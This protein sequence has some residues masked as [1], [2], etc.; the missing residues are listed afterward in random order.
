MA[1]ESGAKNVRSTFCSRTRQRQQKQQQ[2]QRYQNPAHEYYNDEKMLSKIHTLLA[3]SMGT[4]TQRDSAFNENNQMLQKYRRRRAATTIK[5][6][7]TITHHLS[8]HR[9]S[10]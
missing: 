5:I 10:A 9:I 2:R 3:A 6:T 1:C 8:Q 4:M 7:T